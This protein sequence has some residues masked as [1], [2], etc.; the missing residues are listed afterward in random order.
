MADLPQ[1]WDNQ[2]AK[3]AHPLTRMGTRLP[4]VQ[5]I[6]I[7]PLDEAFTIVRQTLTSPHV[8]LFQCHEEWKDWRPSSK[9][10]KH[11]FLSV[12][13][14]PCQRRPQPDIYKRAYVSIRRL[15]SK[16]TM[17]D[18][19][20]KTNSHEGLRLRNPDFFTYIAYIVIFA[21]VTI[22]IPLMPNISWD[23]QI[24]SSLSSSGQP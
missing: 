22:C 19:S 20:R 1:Q 17:T 6:S 2:F 23:F 18:G 16:G 11:L 21:T 9:N 7:A 5:D 15:T 10:E 4:T 8:S 12:S 13:S 24:V 3:S 14:W